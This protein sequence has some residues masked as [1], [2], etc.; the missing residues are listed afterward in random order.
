VTINLVGASQVATPAAGSTPA[1]Y[2]PTSL[3]VSPDT[4]AASTAIS[5]F[6][7]ALNSTLGTLQTLSGYN[8]TTQTAGPLQGNPTIQGFQ[9]QLENI[10][11][12]VTSSKTGINSLSDLGITANAQSGQYDSSTGTLTNALN[13]SLS[14]VEALLAGPNGIATQIN[15]LVTQYTQSGG[16]LSIVNSG[17]QSGLTNVATQ[18]ASLNAELV[19]YSA[20]L[21]TQYNAMD[22]AV[23]SLKEMQT[24]LTAEFNPSSAATSSASSSL[25]SGNTNT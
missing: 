16:V 12:T 5:A 6:V 7:T 21:T 19:T 22:T 3:T 4:T 24:Y 11:D 1:T 8:S 2:T 13:S 25:S 14:G 17:L 10:L 18:Q 15:S 20:T 9:N 23:A